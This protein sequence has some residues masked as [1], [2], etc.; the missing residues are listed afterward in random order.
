MTGATLPPPDPGERLPQTDAEAVLEAAATEVDA[1]AEAV[2]AGVTAIASGRAPTA[3]PT[4]ANAAA[5]PPDHGTRL[6]APDRD[7]GNALGPVRGPRLL[8]GH[9]LAR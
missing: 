4:G 7:R 6:G 2:A 3:I 5:H 1:A 8:R 9:R